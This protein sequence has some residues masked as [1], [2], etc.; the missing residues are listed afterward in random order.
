MRE[1][2]HVRTR[3]ANGSTGRRKKNLENL[4]QSI[5]GSRS[6]TPNAPRPQGLNSS[7]A[8]R[9][10][11]NRVCPS[12]SPHSIHRSDSPPQRTASLTRTNSAPAPRAPRPPPSNTNNSNNTRSNRPREYH[13]DD[14]YNGP[15]EDTRAREPYPPQQQ[16]QQ[17]SAPANG[18]AKN[19]ARPAADAFNV[20]GAAKTEHHI[21]FAENFASGTTAADIEAVMRDVGGEMNSCRL[22]NTDP[23]IAEMD[24]ATRSG[25]A[26]VIDTFDGKKV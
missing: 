1:T 24:F 2:R 7:I 11:V 21:V 26:T 22:T 19:T 17:R 6:R 4:A 9:A 18:R 25:A 23:V 14:Y 13:E 20:R 5:L 15:D 3:H 12:F 8:S 10:G 16:Q